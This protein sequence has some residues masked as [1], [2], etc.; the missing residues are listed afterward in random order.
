MDGGSGWQG[1]IGSLRFRLTDLVRGTSALALLRE[2]EYL[3]FAPRPVLAARQRARR[4]AYADVV[5]NNSTLYRHCA[6]FDQFPVIDKGFANEHRASLMNPAYRGRLLH[7]KTGGSTGQPFVYAT[8]VLAQSY[9]W[10]AILLS[11]RVAGYRLG[12]PVAFLAGSALFGSGRKQRL[13][14][15]LMNVRLWSAFDMSA[16]RMDQCCS[17]LA[18]SRCRLL[19]GYAA[20][21]DRLAIHILNSAVRPRFH[22]RGVVSTAEMLTAPMRARI[23]QA[24]GVRCFSQYGCN[25]AGVS[26]YECERRDGFHLITERC[27]HEVDADGRFLASDMANDAFFLPRYDTG[28]RVAW[29]RSPVPA[30]AAFR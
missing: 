16:A 24:F 25:D 8:G 2:L 20:A 3:Q 26:A 17:E 21:I 13:Y 6:G 4:D 10:A 11:W 19:Y 1:W 29:Q 23:E 27:W 9:L 15:A 30:G 14:Y 28:D 18:G 22:L 12:E 7:K 5:R